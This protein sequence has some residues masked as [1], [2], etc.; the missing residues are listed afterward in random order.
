MVAAVAC[1]AI[2]GLNFGVDFQGGTTIRTES[3]QAVNVGAYRQAL[4][5]LDL[6]TWR[7]PRS[8][9]FLRRGP[10]CRADPPWRP[11]RAG[12]VNSE[13]I[14]AAQQALQAVDPAVKLHLRR[15]GRPQG[16]GRARCAR[17]SW[18]SSSPR[19]LVMI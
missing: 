17:P 7:S 10:A 16:L 5:Q 6:A 1:W 18:P 14:A 12:G 11:G 9:T 15:V 3:T 19:S 13:T 2:F 4:L 8:A